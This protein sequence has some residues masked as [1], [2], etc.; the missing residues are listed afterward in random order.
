MPYLDMLLRPAEPDGALAVARVH[1]RSWQAAYRTL[2]R[3]QDLDQLCPQDR[4]QKYDFVTAD[5]SRAADD[6]SGGR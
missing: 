5:L 4:G 2:L 1:V 3:D 6:R